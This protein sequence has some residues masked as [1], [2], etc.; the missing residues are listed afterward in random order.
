MLGGT[1]EHCVFTR[2]LKTQA[3]VDAVVRA[4]IHTA[5]D[6]G[7]QNM[8][9]DMQSEDECLST[10]AYHAHY[11]LCQKVGAAYLEKAIVAGICEALAVG[12]RTARAKRLRLEQAQAQNE[13]ERE[14]SE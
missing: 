14:A 3:E 5:Y 9:D 10:A 13:G 1:P 4:L 12:Y 8:I 11:F 6:G 2:A 7:L